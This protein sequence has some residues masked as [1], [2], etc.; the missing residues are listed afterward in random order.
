MMNCMGAKERFSRLNDKT[1]ENI[2]SEGSRFNPGTSESE[3]GMVIFEHYEEKNK[4][5]W[6]KWNKDRRGGRSGTRRRI[7]KKRT[8]TV[9]KRKSVTRRIM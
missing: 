4:A 3:T 2:W 8:V 7:R 5:E 6:K 1:S 9:W